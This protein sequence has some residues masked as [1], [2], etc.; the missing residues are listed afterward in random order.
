MNED[1]ER[2]KEGAGVP[3]VVDLE[4]IQPK[5][6]ISKSNEFMSLH[7]EM[8]GVQRNVLNAILTKIKL[9]KDVEYLEF[10][11][12]D[13]SALLGLKGTNYEQFRDAF[14]ALSKVK[15]ETTDL[16]SITLSSLITESTMMYNSMA[17]RLT[18]SP[19]AKRFFVE[20]DET[21]PYTKQLFT[22]S[23]WPNVYTHEIWDFVSQL[24][25]RKHKYD[26]ITLEDFRKRCLMD[27]DLYTNFFDFRR[28]ILE[29]AKEVINAKTGLKIDYEPIKVGRAVVAIKFI[30]L[31]AS[32]TEIFEP[33]KV[34]D[35]RYR[36]NTTEEAEKI[37][38]SLRKEFTFSE[39]TN[40]QLSVGYPFEFYRS[41]ISMYYDKVGVFGD[42]KV[43]P[44]D[45]L[46]MDFKR[47]QELRAKAAMP[48]YPGRK[49]GRKSEPLI[50]VIKVIK[51]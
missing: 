14:D 26:T 3:A 36:L 28:R 34:L 40:E 31:E 42:P 43:L 35:E 4:N 33:V 50:K 1:M 48:K 39:E 20:L 46:L 15:I 5:L 49:K 11:L 24:K 18:L 21:T 32:N 30:V 17:V 9:K 37:L 23:I 47:I 51:K 25:S 2:V 29:P 19:V 12:K 44:A 8:S 22:S 10:Q 41:L 13:I 38:K 7:K 16:T 45:E 27:P 6:F